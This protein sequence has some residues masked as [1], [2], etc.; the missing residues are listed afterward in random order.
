[1]A[2]MEVDKKTESS[3]CRLGLDEWLVAQCKSVGISRPSAIQHHCIPPILKGND[4]IGCAKTGSGKTAAFALPILQKL[5]EDP[6][7]VFAVILTPT[8]ELAYQISEH[9][10]V[11]GKPMK[12][13]D[14][15]V[16]GGVDM[17][18]QSKQLERKPHIV[19][20]TP[21]RLA[22]HLQSSNTLD[23]KSIQF[24]VLDEADRL[25]E[26]N[27]GPD[28]EVIFEAL[29]EKRQTLLFS[30]TI[31]D[32]MYEL[33]KVAMKKPFFWSSNAP[34]VTV[35]QLDQRYL[36]VPA[37]VKDAYLVQ[38]LR[39][40]LEEDKD[41]SIIIFTGTC[42]FCHALS[43]TLRNLDFP[44]V[45]LHSLVKQRIRLASLAQF[46]SNQVR[47]MVATDVASRGLDIPTVQ[48]IINHNVPPS[49]KDY[50]HRVGRTARAGRGGM[51]ITM[52]TQFDVKVVKNI[53][54]HIK[55][56]LTEFKM[57]E[58][59]V[60]PILN[61]VAIAKSQ[62]QMKLEEL[63][64]GE[65]RRINKRKQ[66]ILEGKDPEEEERKKQKMIKERKKAAKAKREERRKATASQS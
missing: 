47:L 36:L 22:D 25:L 4:C 17:I 7:G 15:V 10:H 57:E 44:N 32:T 62:A 41:R 3:F 20:A 28:L 60:L 19:I 53:E 12:L 40:Y 13:K 52:V 42:K 31:T 43:I 64:F 51:A 23:L 2:D 45:A 21:G 65:K 1:M 8:R 18:D 33:R 39:N 6:Y 30:A 49:P 56:K 58:K 14:C 34:I 27:F 11:L 9:F 38:F 24:L 48:L 46:K 66:M 55:T 5:S 37:Q 59:E 54:K 63:D 50:V 26:G 29:P 16:V 61:E 35:E